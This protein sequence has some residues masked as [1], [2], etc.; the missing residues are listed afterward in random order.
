MPQLAKG[1]K[2]V[3][4]W[5]VVGLKNEIHI[6]PDASMAYGFQPGETVRFTRGSRS[7]GG[8]GIA[9]PGKLA[10]SRLRGRFIGQARMGAYGCVALPGEVNVQPG[11]RLLVV[12]GS[13]L[14]LGF[15]KRGLIFDEALLHD[16]I[17]VFFPDHSS[18]Q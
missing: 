18:D 11:E 10:T 14:A 13:W 17:Q 2:W 12:C 9:N 1:G 4:G 3:Y 7:S 6:P 15:V 8:F 5:C 16:E